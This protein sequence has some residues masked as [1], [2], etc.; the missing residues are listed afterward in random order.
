MTFKYKKV[1]VG[2]TFDNLHLGHRVLLRVAFNNGKS[3]II[4]VS[5]DNF[6]RRLGKNLNHDLPLRV[7]LLKKF[8]DS[9]FPN[10]YKICVLEDYFGPIATK[11]NIDAIVVSEETASKAEMANELRIDKGL[12]PLKIIIID[13]VLADDGLPISSTRIKSGEIDVEGHIIKSH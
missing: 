13:T 4:G 11:A 2:G 6:A 12:K 1:A 8:L 3:I 5:S 10:R 9:E 7:K